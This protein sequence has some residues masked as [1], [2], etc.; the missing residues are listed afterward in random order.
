L[1]YLLFKTARERR[2]IRN[3]LIFVVALLILPG[4]TGG[5][6]GIASST[7]FGPWLVYKVSY[8]ED[9]KQLEKSS[10]EII[11]NQLFNQGFK[12]NNDWRTPWI[13]NVRTASFN[14]KYGERHIRI[15]VEVSQDLIILM[16]FAYSGDTKRVFE[17]LKSAL[18]EL[19]GES[20]VEEC[21]GTKGPRGH[22]CFDSISGR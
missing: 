10:E 20:S 1:L 11:E 14:Q 19:Y 22:S 7:Y 3:V 16:S 18:I 2:M 4:C 12:K 17:T 13:S 5:L 21:F 9:G 8:P 6:S 15:D